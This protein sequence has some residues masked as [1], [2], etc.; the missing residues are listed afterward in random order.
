M[1]YQTVLVHADLS[2]HAP[3]LLRQAARLTG[4][5]DAHLMGVA[6]I[7]MSRAVFPRGDQAHAGSLEASYFEPL[8]D[9]AAQ[10]LDHVDTV[11]RD[12]GVSHETRLVWHLASDAL[13]RVAR[14]A[15]LVVVR[16]YDPDEALTEPGWRIP[17]YDALT[18]AHPVLIAR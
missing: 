10:A 17:E 9:S 18:S 11:A 8:R 7:G 12:V 6:A 13:A 14:F 16:Q 2:R 1:N 15:D 3:E 5:Y 4:A